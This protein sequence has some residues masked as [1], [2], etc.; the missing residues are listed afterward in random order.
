MLD[1]RMGVRIE[2]VLG[3]KMWSGNL[4]GMF[5][6]MLRRKM[7]LAIILGAIKVSKINVSI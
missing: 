4:L 6:L 3:W 2:V 5:S 7:M 1:V